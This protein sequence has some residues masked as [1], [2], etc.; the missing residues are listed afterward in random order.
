MS[1]P[2]VHELE[3]LLQRVLAKDGR[4]FNELLA[5]LRRYMHGLVRQQLGAPTDGPID[6]SNLVQ[7]ALR[8][9][10]VHF[11]ELEGPTVPLLLG[12]VK[13]IVKNR[14]I[15]ELRRVAGHPVTALG[16]D[17]M[18]LAD[19]RPAADSQDRAERAAAVAAALA[20]LPDRLRRVVE[21]RWFE[22]QPDETTARELGITVNHVRQL[23]F[24]ALEKL[25]PLLKHWEEASL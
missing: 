12:W 21:T 20:Q 18:I 14:V 2:D 8:R 10:L 5:R 16:S 11:D 7:S 22:R 6:Y 4:A 1:T 19:P 13:S 24:Q 3:P 23:R 9:V 17:V 25:R 15:D